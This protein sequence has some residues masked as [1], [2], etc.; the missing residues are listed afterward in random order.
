VA[1]KPFG[2]DLFLD[3]RYRRT[4]TRFCVYPQP[5]FMAGFARPVTIHVDAAPGTI[6]PGPADECLYVVDARNKRPYQTTGG[7]PPYT[8][9]R[10]RPAEPNRK[11]HFDEIA[12]D[13]E[14]FKSATTYGVIKCVLDIWETY[15]GRRIAWHFR[16]TYPRLEVIPRVREFN[17]YSMFGFVEFGEGDPAGLLCEN[18]D[19]VAHEVGHLI[20]KAVI[21]NPAQRLVEFRAHEEACADMVAILSSLHFSQVVDRLLR[22]TQGRLFAS[23]IVTR[24]GESVVDRNAYNNFTMADVPWDPDP[25]TYKYA[26]ALPFAGAVFDLLVELYERRLVAR[27]AISPRLAARSS[28]ARARSP[29]GLRQEFARSFTRHEDSFK[30]ALADARD[31]LGMLLTRT[32]QATPVTDLS[33]PRVV[34]A[35]LDA[36]AQL[37]GRNGTLIRDCF[38]QRLIRPMRPS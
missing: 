28:H 11:G 2:R 37:G 7:R 21:G 16:E 29:R 36:D 3:T 4:G 25:D 27:G 31:Y 8:G 24:I 38:A 26:L 14:S 20:L 15:L 32:W 34:G 5:K 10:L 19:T 13:D 9:P 35:M 1:A 6:A 12:P 22:R 18:F 23:S 17:A 33:Y 30:A